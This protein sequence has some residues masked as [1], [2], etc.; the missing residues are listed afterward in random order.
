MEL[1]EKVLITIIVLSVLILIVVIGTNFGLFNSS[2]KIVVSTNKQN[3]QIEDLLKVQIE[4]NSNDDFCFSSCYPYYIE[5]ESEK[6]WESYSYEKCTSDD[7]VDKC[8]NTKEEKAFQFTLPFL[9]KGL[10][11]LAIPVCVSCN[12]LESFEQ[13]KWI[14][15]NEFIIN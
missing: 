8:L 4:N 5:R 15:S 3:Y 9:E 1:K 6:G 11:R 12:I 13:E 2:E 10:H 14:Y 7:L